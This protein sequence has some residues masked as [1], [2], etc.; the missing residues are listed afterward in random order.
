MKP[1]AAAVG[2]AVAGLALSGPGP[3]LSTAYGSGLSAPVIGTSASSAI[4][5]DPAAVYWNPAMLGPLLR[6][7]KS[8]WL[9]GASIL[10]LDVNFDRERLG[11]YQHRDSLRFRAPVPE[12]D[13]D[14]D[15]TGPAGTGR[16]S[17]F[18]PAPAP[19][20]FFGY[21]LDDELSVGMGMFVPFGAVLEFPDDGPQ[22]W[23]LQS[24]EL[25]SVEVAAAAAWRAN[26]DLTIGVGAG[27]VGGMLRLRKVVDLASTPLLA[28]AFANPPI[29][30][31]N[32]FGPD[33][34]SEVRELDVLSREVDIGPGLGWSWVARAGIEWRPM[35]DLQLGVG[36]MYRVP[37]VFH[38]GF[39]LD[40][41]DP[42]FTVDLEPQGL[43]YPGTIEGQAEV[44]F[45]L[46]PSLNAGVSYRIDPRWMVGITSSVFFNSVVDE[47]VASLSSNQLVQPE[48]GLGTDAAV[49]LPRRWSD[50]VQVELRG[51]YHN[52]AW[53]LGGMFGYHTAASPEETVDVASPDGPRVTVGF[54]G[55]YH[56][57][58]FDLL[59]GGLV[60]LVG[61]AHVQYVLPRTVTQS[62]YDLANGE[63]T[64]LLTGV[65]GALRVR[66][67]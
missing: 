33:A 48:L 20:L 58:A 54:T 42:L 57:G 40:M 31:P 38:G 30:Q 25:L 34:P 11:D 59:G 62:D 5:R 45:P 17:G 46:P 26:D 53:H 65:S 66:F 35:D 29:G 6:D 63:I 60:D 24:V 36:Y 9:V 64:L 55:G 1:I 37:M 22:K 44:E 47:L 3:M 4:N 67:N 49:A 50:T 39:V 56:L 18:I 15:R 8:D 10:Y 43:K 51:M 52:D 7:R 21:A 13:L 2:A 12:E 19:Q 23:A 41:N 28:A 61:D 14:P 16:A 32:S 27:L